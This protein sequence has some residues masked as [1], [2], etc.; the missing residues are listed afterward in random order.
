MELFLNKPTW[1]KTAAD[2]TLPEDPNQWEQEIWNEMHKQV[3]YISDFDVR[4]QIQK[5]EP[6][7][8]YGYGFLEVSSKTHAQVGEDPQK[9]LN[10]GIK[11]A[12][13]PILIVG[14]KL[15]PFD[16][17]VTPDSGMY[18]LTEDRLKQIL[19]RPQ[20][21][22]TTANSPGDQSMIG[23]L[24]PPYRQTFGFGGGGGIVTDP[25][26]GMKMASAFE[27]FVMEKSADLKTSYPS[28][29]ASSLD[30]AIK[31][32][33]SDVRQKVKDYCKYVW[34][35]TGLKQPPPLST[36]GAYTGGK[37]ASACCQKCGKDK[38]ACMKKEG[39][40]I[41]QRTGNMLSGIGEIQSPFR[42]TGEAGFGSNNTTNT[43]YKLFESHRAERMAREAAEAA[44]EADIRRAVGGAAG[45]AALTVP[46]IIGG[47][48]YMG[49]Q[50]G[51]RLAEAGQEAPDVSTGKAIA[52]SLFWPYGAYLAGR[53]IGHNRNR[54]DLEKTSSV[55]S[56]ILPSISELDFQGF[57]A[58]LDRDQDAKLAFANNPSASEAL[59]KLASYEPTERDLVQEL[60]E[61][62]NYNIAQIKH[63]DGG[64]Y[65]VKVASSSSW[66][67]VSKIL[68]RG[69]VHDLFGPKVVLA[70]DTSGSVTMAEG[71]LTENSP[72]SVEQAQP[73]KDF[74]MYKVRSLDGKLLIGYVFPNLYE[75]DGTSVPLA[76]FTN[77]SDHALQGEI[78]GIKISEGASVME[79]HP[80]GKG[81]FVRILPNGKAEATVPME[82][83]VESGRDN[84][85][86]FLAQGY[87]GQS[88]KVSQQPN[89]KNIMSVD[90]VTVIPDDFHWMPLSGEAVVLM[91]DPTQVTKTAEH[92]RDLMSVTIRG[93]RDSY[94][95]S[96]ECVAKLAQDQKSFLSTDD[97]LFLLAGV[98]VNPNLAATKLGE[99]S[100]GFRPV[101]VPFT[102][103]IK[104]AKDRL[105]ESRK[106]AQDVQIRSLRPVHLVKEAA[107]INDPMALDT[108]L[109]LGFLNEDN[110]LEFVDSL[111]KIEDA[112][113]KM[114]ELLFGSRVGMTEIPEE[115]LER[116][117]R[118]TEK[119]LSA[120]KALA[121][122]VARSGMQNR[123]Q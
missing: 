43:I 11:K 111:P 35:N 83:H 12:R 48:G 118:A 26:G 33:A 76:L 87:S 62:T 50:E 91:S 44:E 101:S 109:S 123:I 90:G 77:G 64:M 89:I 94:S 52:G 82:I 17:L 56:S 85:T 45:F 22:D 2:T 99:A 16:L 73:I 117:I 112:Q 98:G 58:D 104:L 97:A 42:T 80:R 29:G 28:A 72:E 120:L 39:A 78:S 54:K 46:G 63:L 21:F 15:K 13:V 65:E 108:V 55:L 107:Y 92:V 25:G 10:A 61:N 49:Y 6:E 68:N 81:C 34:D 32:D 40:D 110:I 103:T 74:G 53:H 27:Q 69:E 66:D 60:R 7:K 20:T 119:V 18:P 67:P 23:M 122:H 31:S 105:E 36:E 121:F 59:N 95:L 41:P 14:G 1:V 86:Y 19:F 75:L 51:K 24:F 113:K 47:S 70:A 3:P 116:S 79:G 37:Q 8:G 100:D 102:R 71:V 30:E 93:T 9:L 38:C 84:Q 96:G 106:L 88:F 4:I 57:L 115:P 114:C 5:V